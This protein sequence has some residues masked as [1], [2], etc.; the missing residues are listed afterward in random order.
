M[1][2]EKK[3]VSPKHKAQS[4]QQVRKVQKQSIQFKVSAK[5]S[6]LVP[7]DIKNMHSVTVGSN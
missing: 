1:H 3:G 4:S 2:E 7:L 6:R 5:V